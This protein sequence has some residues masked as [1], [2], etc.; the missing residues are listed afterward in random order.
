MLLST[1]CAGGAS[2]GRPAAIPAPVQVADR[3]APPTDT[4]LV[5]LAAASPATA[6]D[7]SPSPVHPGAA[8]ATPGD[9][10]ADSIADET[11][12]EELRGAAPAVASGDEHAVRASA[13]GAE[14][15]EIAAVTW[16]IDVTS[17]LSHERVQ[18]YLDFFQGPA[19]ERF[20]AWLQRMPRYE[21]LIRARLARQG[22]PGD[23][24]YLALIE[25][26][27]SNSATSRTR[28]VGMWQFMP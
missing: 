2:H 11:V 6:V 17:F 21:S 1:A 10:G 8:L 28:A 20:G 16:D 9:S 14:S 15:H 27:F 19:R 22:L 24:I 7:P 5:P 3:Q 13:G 4:T 26:G 25:S 18:Y 12:L 23:L